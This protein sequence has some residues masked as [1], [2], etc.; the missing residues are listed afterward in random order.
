MGLTLLLVVLVANLV[1]FSYGRGVVRAALDEGV[2]AGAR[3]TASAVTC[4]QRAREVLGDLLGGAMGREVAIACAD[5]VDRVTATADVRFAGWLPAVP[6]WSFRAA[7]TARR[8][9]EPTP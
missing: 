9:S 5:G 1:V 7:A 4:E 6:D 3:V 2:R 8:R